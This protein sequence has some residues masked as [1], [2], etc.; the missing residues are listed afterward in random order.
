MGIDSNIDKEAENINDIQDRKEEQHIPEGWMKQQ[1]IGFK[2]DNS[3]LILE[4]KTM[5]CSTC[6]GISNLGAW[7]S[8]GCKIS[9]KWVEGFQL[10]GTDTK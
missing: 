6:Y 9:S 5:K 10:I 8:N 1:A 3:F 7:T 4:N 2:R